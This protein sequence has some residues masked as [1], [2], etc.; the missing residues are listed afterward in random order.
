MK[1]VRL[2]NL[3]R[4]VLAHL[5][6]N[7]LRNKFDALVKQVSGN[8]DVLFL[9]ETKIDESFP[10]GQF[11]TPEFCTPFRLDRNRFSGGIL[12]YVQEN[13]PAKPLSSEAKT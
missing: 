12:V 2:K 1:E 5:N 11:K 9:S 10:E 6:I 8:V 4:I 13:I 7:S 3:N